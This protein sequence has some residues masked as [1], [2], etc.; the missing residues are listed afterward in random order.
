MELIQREDFF[1]AIDEFLNE[2]EFIEHSLALR[3]DQKCDEE[4][5]LLLNKI[6]S[7]TV[8]LHHF[9]KKV[10]QAKEGGSWISTPFLGRQ[11]AF[12]I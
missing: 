2:V 7:T 9:E 6:Q 5:N 8:H 11:L 1:R 12:N 3:I 4:K 10:S